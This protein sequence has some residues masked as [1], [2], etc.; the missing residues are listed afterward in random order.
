MVIERLLMSPSTVPSIWMSPS[1]IRS[2]LIFRS[3]LMID[4]AAVR[5]WRGAP[6]P[7]PEL[8]CSAST[9]GVDVDLA[10]L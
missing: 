2:P 6:D 4:G 8:P 10:I 1:Q 7:R 3:G 9:S 5:D